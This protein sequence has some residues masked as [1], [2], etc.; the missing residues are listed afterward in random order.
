VQKIKGILINQCCGK[1]PKL[2]ALEEIK[3]PALLSESRLSC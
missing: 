2:L 3:K 1:V